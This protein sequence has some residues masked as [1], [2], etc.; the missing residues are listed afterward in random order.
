[1]RTDQYEGLP[2]V[3]A[4]NPNLYMKMKFPKREKGKTLPLEKDY[5][6]IKF[7]QTIK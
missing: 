6:K 7:G 1:M 2:P 4:K 3:Q 5:S